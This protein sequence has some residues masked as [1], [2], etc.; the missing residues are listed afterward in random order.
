MCYLI[1][2]ILKP[3]YAARCS[4]G[5]ALE[6]QESRLEREQHRARRR[7]L[8]TPIRQRVRR[9]DQRILDLLNQLVRH[10]LRLVRIGRHQSGFLFCSCDD[11]HLT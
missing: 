8:V 1:A 7:Q 6:V 2:L 11:V 5:R 3:D 9:Q 4:E 10:L